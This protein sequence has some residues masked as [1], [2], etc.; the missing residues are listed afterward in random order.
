VLDVTPELALSGHVCTRHQVVPTFLAS[1]R[2]QLGFKL[3]MQ[4][5][6]GCGSFRLS[7]LTSVLLLLLSVLRLRW[8]PAG[9]SE[10]AADQPGQVGG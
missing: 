2:L 5:D 7:V 9:Q 1:A 6:G 3:Y 10:A 4:P 8:G